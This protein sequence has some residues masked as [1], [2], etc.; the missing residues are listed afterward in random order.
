[1]GKES[2]AKKET[3]DA[4]EAYLQ[5]TRRG[6]R[7][8]QVV[9]GGL[10]DWH[11]WP[12]GSPSTQLAEGFGW[13]GLSCLSGAVSSEPE[14][15]RGRERLSSASRGMTVADLVC[16]LVTLLFLTGVIES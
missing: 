7:I 5:Q 3:A 12:S 13:F 6:K 16:L 10:A 1:M 15:W 11:A 9:A 14:I 8:E 4:M 2:D